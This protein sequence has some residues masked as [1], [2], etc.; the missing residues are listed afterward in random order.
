[1]ST[2]GTDQGGAAAPA[3]FDLSSL[4]GE[5]GKNFDTWFGADRKAD[6]IGDNAAAFSDALIN[7]SNILKGG[8]DENQSNIESGY[9]AVRAIKDAGLNDIVSILTGGT[10]ASDAEL[11][12][13]FMKYGQFILPRLQ[14][15]KG[16]MNDA[17]NTFVNNIYDTSREATGIYQQGAGD[18]NEVYKPYTD[19]GIKALQYMTSILGQ[20]PSQLDPAQQRAYQKIKDQALA[21]LAASGLRGA[22]RGG[23]AAVNEGLAEAMANFES[24]NRDRMDRAATAL[25]SQGY[26]ASNATA[27]NIKNLTDS[28]ANLAYK[29][30]QQA[31]Q[32]RFNTASDNNA[33]DLSVATDIGSKQ[34]ATQ[35]KIADQNLR[36]SGDVANTV[37]SYYDNIGDIEGN[38]YGSRGNT[39][40]L[41]AT[42]DAAAAGN[43]GTLDY[44][45][46]TAQDKVKNDAIGKISNSLSEYLKKNSGLLIGA[47]K[48]G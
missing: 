18:V 4:I 16:G 12:D 7:S 46:T 36:T 6:S 28:V 40:L 31:S 41:K 8:L 39:A 32:Q 13:A 29:T 9:D 34:Y 45:T 15:Y 35:N 14:Q 47:P 22:G 44:Y 21:T 19:S 27:A 1:M 37:G 2:I 42:S 30:G 33:K 17:T 25:N 3:E 24:D 20:D 26:N 10:Q 43:A 38:R 48:N 5:I 11:T 23:V